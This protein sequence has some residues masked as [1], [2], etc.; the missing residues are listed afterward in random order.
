MGPWLSSYGELQGS[1]QP[2][3]YI[4]VLGDDMAYSLALFVRELVE[5]TINI[6]ALACLEAPGVWAL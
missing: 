2:L 1:V 4:S 6:H 3:G 5:V